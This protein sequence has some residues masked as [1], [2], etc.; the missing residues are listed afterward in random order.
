MTWPGSCSTPRGVGD[1]RAAQRPTR[2]RSGCLPKY[3]E[4]LLRPEGGQS[5]P[6]LIQ[7]EPFTI[8]V[9][10]EELTDLRDRICQRRS[11]IDPLPPAVSAGHCKIGPR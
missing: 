6:E 11:K 7:I 2:S 3:I 9:G 5:V 4:S 10:D 8:S 1:G